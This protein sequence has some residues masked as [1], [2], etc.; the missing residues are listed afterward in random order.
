MAL[1]RTGTVAER[2]I[3]A[4]D[5][6]ILRGTRQGGDPAS[7]LLAALNHTNGVMV[8]QQHV[9]MKWCFWWFFF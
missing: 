4:V 8:G 3:I 6:K 5:N 2:R 1:P 7:H 9:D